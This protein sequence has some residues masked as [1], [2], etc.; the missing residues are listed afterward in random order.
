MR[1]TILWPYCTTSVYDHTGVYGHNVVL[2]F[3]EGDEGDDR[4]SPVASGA[5]RP[6]QPMA[7]PRLDA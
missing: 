4:C 6:D 2:R 5:T 7:W 1:A 3:I